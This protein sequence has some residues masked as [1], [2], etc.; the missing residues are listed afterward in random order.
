MEY[1]NWNICLPGGYTQELEGQRERE[2]SKMWRN[3]GKLFQFPPL[4]A[5]CLMR[6]GLQKIYQEICSYSKWLSA[7][8]RIVVALLRIKKYLFSKKKEPL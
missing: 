7:Y 5:L 8:I 3:E 6:S 2:E 1:H 4:P